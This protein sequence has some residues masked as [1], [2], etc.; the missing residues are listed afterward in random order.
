MFLML[1]TR[2]ERTRQMIAFIDRIDNNEIGRH[3]PKLQ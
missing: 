3:R 1:G 2:I